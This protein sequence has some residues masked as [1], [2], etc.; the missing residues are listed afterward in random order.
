MINR[1]INDDWDISQKP[2]KFKQ[3]F[4][5]P[6]EL[7]IINFAPFFGKREK[8]KYIDFINKLA[9][10]KQPQQ[11]MYEYDEEHIMFG[12]LTNARLIQN[13]VWVTFTP[14]KIGNLW[15]SFAPSYA[16][17]MPQRINKE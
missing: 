3:D 7:E 14:Q 6:V 9:K 4:R 10:H 17:T 11:F 1:S 13:K 5:E 16:K 15:V 12:H 2:L 8:Q